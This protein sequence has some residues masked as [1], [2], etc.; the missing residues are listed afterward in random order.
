[1]SQPSW[2]QHPGHL[3]KCKLAKEGVLDRIRARHEARVRRTRLAWTTA[4][5]MSIAACAGLFITSL[6]MRELS[7]FAGCFLTSIM[8]GG[9]GAACLIRSG[10][11]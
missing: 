10:A 7:D 3:R 9:L 6:G 4:G 2:W 5:A 1:M 8:L 11:E